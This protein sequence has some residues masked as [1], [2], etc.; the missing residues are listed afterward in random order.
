ADL[1]DRTD[2][3][4]GDTSMARTTGLP[5]VV[6][7]RRI[8]GGHAM[9]AGVLPAERIAHDRETFDLLLSELGRRGVRLSFE[10]VAVSGAAREPGGAL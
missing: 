1:L 6:V 10:T 7:A 8:V 3:G 2:P 9:P 4:T 5:A